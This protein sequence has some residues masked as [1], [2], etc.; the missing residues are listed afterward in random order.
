ML[1]L[2]EDVGV[3]NPI[4]CANINKIGFRMCGG[5]DLY[6]KTLAERKFRP[7]AMSVLASGAI[8]PQEA[9][10]YVCRLPNVKAIVFGASSRGNI[11]QIRALVEQM[12]FGQ[13]ASAKP[14]ERP[15]RRTTAGP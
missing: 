3:K 12:H 13:T 9:I 7:I 8:Q 6:E 4:I 15:P 14:G 2:L 5:I 10:A 1:D 11:R